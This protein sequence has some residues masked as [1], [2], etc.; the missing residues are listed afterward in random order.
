M[1]QM[2]YVVAGLLTASAACSASG[3][4]DDPKPGAGDPQPDGGAPIVL[5]DAGTLDDAEVDLDA[6][7]PLVC[8]DAGFCETRLPKSELGLPLSLQS[9]WVVGSNDV[10]SVTA[11][12]V[13]L[14]HDG[15]SWKTDHRA[16]H[17]LSTVW[18]TPTSVWAGGESGLLLHRATDGVWTRVETGHTSMIRAIAGT[19][20]ADVWFVSDDG[21]V[22]HFD[23]STLKDYP[24]EIPGLKITT[25]FGRSGLGMYAA[26]Y[27]KDSAPQPEGW[28]PLANVRPCM[29]A[30]SPTG[31]SVF[32]ST[33]QEHEGFVPVSAA[34]T[35]APSDPRSVFVYGYNYYAYSASP[36][37]FP[38]AAHASFGTTAQVTIHRVSNPGNYGPAL[39]GWDSPSRY[40]VWVRGWNDVLVP[41]VHPLLSIDLWRWNGSEQRNDS[42]A[43]GYGF[44][45]RAIF[46]MHG[47]ATDTWIVGDGFALKGT[48]P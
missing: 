36:P 31:V 2:R 32:N 35:E 34:I 43:M 21:L 48:T 41:F 3:A 20:D 23:G 11:E 39:D 30:L 15:A 42:L 14:H 7:R 45:P 27:V 5:V 25:V 13:V 47:N 38:I 24:I 10:W 40:P 26:G 1:N 9:V 19:S 17:V 22:D 33:L 6:E 37:Y 44:V 8:G 46:G 12:G 18:A 29:F 4:V 16:N 28:A